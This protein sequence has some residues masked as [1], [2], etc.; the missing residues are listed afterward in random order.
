MSKDGLAAGK[1]LAFIDAARTYAVLLVLLAHALNATGT[2]ARIGAESLLIQQFTRMATPLFVFIFGFMIEFVYVRKAMHLGPAAVR[3]RLFARSL[4]CYCAYALTSLSS[5]VGGHKTYGDVLAS[6]VFFNNSRFGNI[7]RVYA[8]LLLAVPWLIKLRIRFGPVFLLLALNVVLL[9][10]AVLVTAKSFSFGPL[11]YPLNILCGIGPVTGGPSIWHSLSF[12]LAGMYVATGLQEMDNAP[13]PAFRT[14]SAFLLITVSLLGL[15][16]ID[17]APGTAWHKFVD[18]SY[19]SRNMAGYYII[20][21]LC[22]TTVMLLFAMFLGTRAVPFPFSVLLPL[23]H[24]SLFAYTFGNILLN[25]SG[26]LAEKM[27]LLFFLPLFFSLVFCGTILVSRGPSWIKQPAS[28]CGC[29]RG[30]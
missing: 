16:L 21:I 17:D 6:L 28:P 27:D 26:P 11:D 30:L 24:S 29:G 23:G 19:R 25:L 20:G 13:L 22:S 10:S 14:A 18:F 5:A 1:R 9:S 15:I 2:F 12:L 8:V 7:L 4:H 3:P